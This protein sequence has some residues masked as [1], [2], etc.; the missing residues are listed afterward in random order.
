VVALADPP[1]RT[2]LV[3]RALIA[4]FTEALA[5]PDP[6]LRVE[7]AAMSRAVAGL[8]PK[9]LL[10]DGLEMAFPAERTV[11]FIAELVRV[12]QTLRTQP[13]LRAAIRLQVFIRTDLFHQPDYENIEQLAQGRTLALSW[14]HKAAL[15]LL[16]AKL[17]T[18][19]WYTRTFST[20]V[21]EIRRLEPGLRRAEVPEGVCEDALALIFPEKAGVANTNTRTFWR[22]WF[23]EDGPSGSSHF[24]RLLVSFLDEV[25]RIVQGDVSKGLE[26]Q[27]I[28]PWVLAEAHAHVTQGAF[29]TATLTE[30]AWML[31]ED[32]QKAVEPIVKALQGQSTPF[33]R[34]ELERSV[35]KI[36][37][38][39]ARVTRTVFD[40]M[41]GLGMFET[42]ANRPDRWRATRLYRTALRMKFSR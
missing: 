13:Q 15:N 26:D 21:D 5:T 22:T 31:P 10:I 19:P 3:D 8:P 23:C 17:I 25:Q 24:P 6:S 1:P 40:A 9:L 32:A 36:A 33:V 38:V 16:L 41:L 11:K 2:G 18:L 42:V 35:Y 34:V 20:A 30:L 4:A 37:K 29:R 12:V 27:H 7:E 39:G 28:A 14:T